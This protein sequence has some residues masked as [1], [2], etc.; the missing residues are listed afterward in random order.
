M[1]DEL[2]KLNMLE[3]SFQKIHSLDDI[4]DDIVAELTDEVT[5]LRMDITGME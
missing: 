3:G 5:R 1:H 4:N 2:G